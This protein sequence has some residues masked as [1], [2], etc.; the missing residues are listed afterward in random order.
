[1]ARAADDTER[2]PVDGP[3][4]SGPADVAA[5]VPIA[6]DGPKRRSDGKQVHAPADRRIGHA[7][8]PGPFVAVDAEVF[9]ARTG[10]KTGRAYADENGLMP[11][12]GALS[13]SGKYFA[14]QTHDARRIPQI[15]VI[16]CASGRPIG[17]VNC[18]EGAGSGPF[19]PEH[20]II[21]LA[22]TS[23][24]HLFAVATFDTMSGLFLWDLSEGKLLKKFPAAR[25]DAKY[26]KMA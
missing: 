26:V 8:G 6:S 23:L 3:L 1:V 14:Y 18:L 9:D 13:P 24:D 21:F 4:W 7:S 5:V 20:G 10:V 12:L 25:L 19:V 16:D 2:P 22:F 15:V 17:T 11:L